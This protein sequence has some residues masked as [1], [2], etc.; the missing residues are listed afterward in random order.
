MTD[1]NKIGFTID[2]PSLLAP[3]IIKFSVKLSSDSGDIFVNHDDWDEL[4]GNLDEEYPEIFLTSN[5][6]YLRDIG[7]NL[8]ALDTVEKTREW[9]LSI[10]MFELNR[11]VK[12]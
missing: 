4:F 7:S 2:E 9:L 6:D 11:Y 5:K 1:F 10:G 8:E 12:S 3:D